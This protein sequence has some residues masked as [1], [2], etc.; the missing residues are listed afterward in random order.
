MS[1]PVLIEREA[2]KEHSQGSELTIETG[3][4]GSTSYLQGKRVYSIDIDP[5][6]QINRYG[7]SPTAKYVK[8]WSCTWDDLIKPGDKDYI[9]SKYYSLNKENWLSLGA[10][11]VFEDN[12]DLSFDFFFCDTGEYC[13]LAEWNIVKDKISI[14]GKFAA[15][16]ILWPKSIKSFKVL[17]KIEASS[18][19]KVLVKHTNSDQGLF[20]AEKIS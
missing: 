16:D 20:V 5:E 11:S 9:E 3:T 1:Q 6:Y 15:H 17:E 2:L 7:Y 12:K 19:W 14:G 10:W 4:G 13:G 18:N 8:G